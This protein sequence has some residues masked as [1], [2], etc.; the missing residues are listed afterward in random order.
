M[1]Q[2]Y[3]KE[4]VTSNKSLNTDSLFF[5]LK[6]IKKYHLCI[7]KILLAAHLIHFPN[8]GS[9]LFQLPF[10]QKNTYVYYTSLLIMKHYIL[11][12]DVHYTTLHIRNQCIIY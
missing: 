2:I 6:F 5:N 8:I 9:K 1:E 11:Y 7:E 10:A 4:S 12:I 3:E